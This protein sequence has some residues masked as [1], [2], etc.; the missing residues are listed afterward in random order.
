[1][2][3]QELLQHAAVAVV[4]QVFSAR[5]LS[6]VTGIRVAAAVAFRMFRSFFWLFFFWGG[7]G[8]KSLEEAGGSGSRSV[9]GEERMRRV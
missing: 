4:P 6:A 3:Q 8:V 5:I 1:M 2:F 9:G 7:G